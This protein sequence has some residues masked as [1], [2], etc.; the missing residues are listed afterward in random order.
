VTTEVTV[1][2]PE[3]IAGGVDAV[4]KGA[5]E[6]ARASAEDE[7]GPYQRV[8]E[9]LGVWP[10][11]VGGGAKGAVHAFGCTDP[12][13]VGWYWAVEVVRVPRSKVATVDDVV[14]LPGAEA[15]RS[16]EWVPWSERLLPGDVGPGDIL[17]TAADDPRLVLRMAD[18][19]GWVDDALW[20]ELGLGRPRVLSALGREEAADRWYDGDHG[21]TAEMAVAAPKQCAD[22]GF[23]VGLV[24][25]LG[26]VFGACTNEMSPA[27]GSVVAQTFGCGA[28][29]E[30]MVLPS[31]QPASLVTDDGEL[32]DV[33]AHGPGSVD[34]ADTADDVEPGG[35]S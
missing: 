22:C 23:Y 17:P 21:P 5:L 10:V 13:Y 1:V 2:L 28:H 34:A 3:V 19:E 18:T 32:Q 14:L 6:L 25:S 27:D 12:A 7:A 8:G 15:V 33:S 24:G 16:P 9:H 30:A 29:S 31:Q 26:R 20:L 35:H 4:L 11:E